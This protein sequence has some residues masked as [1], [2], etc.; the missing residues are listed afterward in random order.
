M[1]HHFSFSWAF[2]S[3]TKQL[4]LTELHSWDRT[5]PNVAVLQQQLCW[6]E[7]LQKCLGF[8]G[9]RHLPDT[10][11][12]KPKV[13]QGAVLRGTF[14]GL[15]SSKQKGVCAHLYHYD[16][17]DSKQVTG[18]LLLFWPEFYPTSSIQPSG[19]QVTTESLPTG[20][21]RSSPSLA[22]VLFSESNSW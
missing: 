16:L 3:I 14:Y 1:I 12:A 8:S 22:L 17:P 20:T 7:K 15:D 4:L 21:I 19:S 11:P 10:V 2:A 9:A 6:G 13:Y 18:Y 5:F